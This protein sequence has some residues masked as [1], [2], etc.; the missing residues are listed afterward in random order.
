MLKNTLVTLLT[1]FVGLLIGQT[2]LSA[3]TTLEAYA[4]EENNRGLLQQVKVTIFELPLNAIRAELVTDT[5]GRFTAVLSPGQYRILL[6]KDVFLDRMDTVQIGQ[7]KTF[8]KI[9]MRRRP[10]YIFDA[11]LAEARET[12][13]QIVD[14][15]Q[16]ANI[17]IYNRTLHRAEKVLTRYPE[18]FFQHNFE[19][20]NHYTMLIRKPGYLAKRIEVYVNVDGCILCVDGVRSMT[21]GITD[22]LSSGNAVGTLLSNIELER[23]KLEKKIEIQN[24]YYDYDKWDIRPDA[25][26]RL[27]LAVQLMKDNPGLSVE[28]GSHT[29]CRGTNAYNRDLSQKRAES[30]VAYIVSEGVESYRITAKGYGESQ[31]ANRCRDGVTCSEAE[32]QQNRRTVLRITGVVND[33]TEY[34]KWPSLEKIILE[35]EAARVAKGKPA[36]RPKS[37]APVRQPEANNSVPLPP[38]EVGPGTDDPLPADAAMQEKMNSLKYVPKA[39]PAHFTGFTIEIARSNKALV[40]ERDT[41]LRQSSGIL[42]QREKQSKTYAYF[43]GQFKTEAEARNFL[44]KEARSKFPEAQV[45]AFKNGRRVK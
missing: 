40:A 45:V 35:E 28:L 29:D 14:A 41:L 26:D 2:K 19:Q 44:E 37:S 23:A 42:L 39:L 43:V 21:P 30:A 11:T 18:A 38:L 13:D 27:D 20:G 15:I 16:G 32:H 25:A 22:N 3:Q 31:L 5:M 10:G 12:P 1:A 34:K 17:E 36:K 9:E 8:R 24:I 33:S 4:Y 7:E 6:H